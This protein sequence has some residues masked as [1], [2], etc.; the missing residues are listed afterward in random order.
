MYYIFFEVKCIV[1]TEEFIFSRQSLSKSISSVL[2]VTD[3]LIKNLINKNL[4]HL[5]LYFK[6]F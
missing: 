3:Y 1:S 4:F 5:L 6:N 2:D